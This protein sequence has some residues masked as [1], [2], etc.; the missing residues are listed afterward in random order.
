MKW[1]KSE[2]KINFGVGWFW[3]PKA[4]PTSNYFPRPC[5]RLIGHTIQRAHN[6]GTPR[7]DIRHTYLDEFGTESGRYH[8]IRSGNGKVSEILSV[9]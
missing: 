7:T 1:P 3:G 6:P 5:I 9:V 2:E 4:P 8:V